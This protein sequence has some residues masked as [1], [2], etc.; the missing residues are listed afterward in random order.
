MRVLRA[1]KARNGRRPPGAI[2]LIS[3]GKSTR[4]RDPVVAAQAAGKVKIPVYTVALGTPSGTLTVPKRGGGTTTEPVPPD[5]TSLAQV[6]R[7]SGGKT[8]TAQ[9]A[10]GLKEVYEK[11]G[12]QL[13]HKKEKR[14]VTSSFAAG[15]L[16][17][18]LLGALM[19]LRWFGRLI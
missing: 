10:S 16:V 19:S 3:D 12:S 5:P 13:G 7:A 17:L 6:A 4:G 14:Q 9:T 1:A 18:L 15:G 11:L 2:V 8:F